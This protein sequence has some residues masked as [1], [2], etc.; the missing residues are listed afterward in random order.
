M[1]HGSNQPANF[2]KQKI[3]AK[4]AGLSLEK[5]PFT[6][7]NRVL[8]EA[9]RLRFTPYPVVFQKLEWFC[10]FSL[11]SIVKPIEPTND[12]NYDTI[13]NSIN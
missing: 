8:Y 4:V 13:N 7:I 10:N 3:V 1:K 9:K 12:N 2:H 5:A 11:A 6:P